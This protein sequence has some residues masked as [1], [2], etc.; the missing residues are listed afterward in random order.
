M[1]QLTIEDTKKPCSYLII[2]STEMPRT[3]NQLWSRQ[4]QTEKCQELL[5]NKKFVSTLKWRS[6]GHILIT[7]ISFFALM[8]ILLVHSSLPR[9]GFVNRNLLLSACIAQQ[10]LQGTAC[11]DYSCCCGNHFF[12]SSLKSCSAFSTVGSSQ[13][14]CFFFFSFKTGTQRRQGYKERWTEVVT[15][16]GFR[17]KRC[18]EP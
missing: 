9:K 14:P 8:V 13:N 12:V 4:D 7:L 1:P 2:T 3:L 15:D 6:V 17:S 10:A 18:P 5:A 16:T 11:Y